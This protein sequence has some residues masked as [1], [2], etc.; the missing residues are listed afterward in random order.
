M[1]Y[2]LLVRMMVIGAMAQMADR[3]NRAVLHVDWKTISVFSEEAR[4]FR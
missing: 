3:A 4:R 1:I 2:E